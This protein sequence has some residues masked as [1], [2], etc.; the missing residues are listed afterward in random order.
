MLNLICTENVLHR[1]R[2]ASA[3]FRR[4]AGRKDLNADMYERIKKEYPY[5]YETHLHTSE[6]SACGRSTGGEMAKAC[7][8]YGYAGIFV[9]DHNWG[10]N[11]AVDERLPWDEWVH[12]FCKGYESARAEG[13]RIGLDV[14]FGYE[15][16][17]G[18]TEFLIYGVDKA[19]MLAHP[20]IR[21]ADI[22]EQYELVHAGGGMVIHAHPYREENYIPRIR[23]FPEWVDGVEG[24]NAMHS[25]SRSLY[26]NA[27]AYDVKAVA[28]AQEHRLPITA[29]SDI[30]RAALLGGGVAFRRKLKSPADYIRAI[31]TGED[32][33]LTNGEYW[34]QKD[35]K[36]LAAE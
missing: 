20:A 33:V 1:S 9:T 15:A 5:L 25:N 32:Y 16:G 13:E 3:R 14:F 27:P 23:L 21:N 29:G 2:H 7:K 30:H 31:L 18:G 17:F 34:Y 10:G 36:C 28:Y 26:H 4:E 35:G 11:T 19:W 8:E 22:Q 6:G 24:V 12:E